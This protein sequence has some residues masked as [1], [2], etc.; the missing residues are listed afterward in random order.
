MRGEVRPRAQAPVDPQLV[1]PHDS[2]SAR[3]EAFLRARYARGEWL[4]AVVS[5][6]FLYEEMH[7]ANDYYPQRWSNDQSAQLRELSLSLIGSRASLHIGQQRVAWGVSELIAPNDVVNARDLRDPLLAQNE[8]RHL[9]TP[10]VRVEGDVL[11]GTLQGL[12]GVFV[13]DD[14]YLYGRAW[15]VVQPDAPV[16]LQA[17]LA[18]GIRS[19]DPT[20]QR[21]FEAFAGQTPLADRLPEDV[22]L[23]A[24]Y[25]RNLNGVDLDLYYHYGFDGTPAFE[26]D[27]TGYRVDYVRRHHAGFDAVKAV[28]PLTARV[29]AAYDSA[30]VFY[31]RE[32]FDAFVAPTVGGTAGLEYT[33][34]DPQHALIL[35]TSALYV[36]SPPTGPLL[37][38]ERL[39]VTT[40]AAARWPI[41]AGFGVDAAALVGIQP[42]TL[43][44]RPEV[45]WKRGAL[46][47]AA[48]LAWLDGTAGSFGWYYRYTS[49]A[50]LR[51]KLSL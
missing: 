51:A 14:F 11:G 10:L 23:G 39:S 37:G 24:R 3:A 42:G 44:L 50:Y 34:D 33:G 18:A 16:A 35:E 19:A 8:L 6:W 7:A 41:G 20:L 46:T 38:Y 43:V 27:P 2:G 4:E 25:Q 36:T 22:T 9:P 15:S 48:G 26:L 49:E 13:P 1:L 29:D 40:G 31:R 5:G 21:H 28:G 47:A 17:Q 12:A 45:T 30:R 32:D